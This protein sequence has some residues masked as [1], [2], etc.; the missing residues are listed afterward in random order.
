MRRHREPETQPLE[1][2]LARNLVSIVSLPA[3]LVDPGGYIV[4]FNEAAA[5][6]IGSRFEETGRLSRG[7]EQA[8]GPFDEEGSRF[9]PRT[10]R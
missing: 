6:I 9:P 7:V 10:C 4:F 2:I 1:L 5:E 8:F 3:F